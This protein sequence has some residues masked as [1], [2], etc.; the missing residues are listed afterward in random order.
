MSK[1][2]LDITSNGGKGILRTDGVV[3]GGSA[4]IPAVVLSGTFTFNPVSLATGVFAESD[5][6]ITGVALGDKVDL[7][8]PYDTQG[9][10][11]Q[12][13]VQA[14]NNVTIALTSCNASTVDLASGTWGYVVTRRV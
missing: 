12:A 13:S 14:A 9:I 7:F 2:G 6:T 10:M 1:Y 4:T 5:V 3:I 11:Y 8:P